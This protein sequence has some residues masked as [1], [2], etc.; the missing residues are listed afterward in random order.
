M[1][2]SRR[3]RG[4]VITTH[5]KGRALEPESSMDMPAV[6]AYAERCFASCSGE[7]ERS[8]MPVSYTHLTLP[9]KRIV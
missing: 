7:G 4:G 3:A 1:Q 2:D 5:T 6:R 8:V 9:T